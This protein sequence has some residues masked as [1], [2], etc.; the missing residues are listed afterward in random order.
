MKSEKG[1]TLMI[2][3]VYLV[4]ITIIMSILAIVSD[5]FFANSKYITEQGKYISEFNKFNM[6]FIADVKNNQATQSVTD[7]EIVFEDGTVYTY[8]PS[9]D[10]GIYR[11]KVKICSHVLLCQFIKTTSYDPTTLLQK[12]VITVITTLQGSKNYTSATDYVL[13]YW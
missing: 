13:K 12:E 6:Y 8:K 10:N 3:V 4:A 5:N 11:N 9:P 1:V 2:L 7:T